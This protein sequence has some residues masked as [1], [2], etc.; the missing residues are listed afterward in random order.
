M[1]SREIWALCQHHKPVRRRPEEESSG[2]RLFL[3]RQRHGHVQKERGEL[4]HGDAV[5]MDYG[6]KMVPTRWN[7]KAIG[8]YN[9]KMPSK[10]RSRTRMRVGFRR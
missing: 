1:T 4:P 7:V 3:E 2:L 5:S 6:L 9:D 10:K 8:L